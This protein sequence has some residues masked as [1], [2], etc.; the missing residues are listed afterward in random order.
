MRQPINNT[1]R[2]PAYQ[3]GRKSTVPAISC[4]EPLPMI[5]EGLGVVRS[6]PG[7]MEVLRT[8]PDKI[9]QGRSATFH[10]LDERMNENILSLLLLR[11]KKQIEN[12]LKVLKIQI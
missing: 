7:L 1:S 6:L 5:G 11:Q 9:D 2:V 3:N 12:F 8:C 10:H 4:V